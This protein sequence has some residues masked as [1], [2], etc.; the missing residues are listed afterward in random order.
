MALRA[1]HTPITH[2][3]PHIHSTT[4]KI[5]KVFNVYQS[6]VHEETSELKQSPEDYQVNCEAWRFGVETNTLRS[7]NVVPPEC[8]EYVKNYM[9]GSG[10]QYVRDSN[11]VANESIAYVN[12][13]QLS[14]DGKD[15]W[16]FDVDETL[17]STLPYFAAHQFGGEVIA[18][19]DFNVKWLDRAVAPALPASHKLYARLLE[20]GFKIFLLTGRR[21]CQRNVTER[22]LVR[23]GYHSWEALFLREPEDR[24]KSAVVYKSE[25]RLKIE[26]NG[27]RIRGNSGD[28]WSDLTGYSVGD[29]TFKLPN[30]MYYVA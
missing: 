15:A 4:R 9:I 10:S 1:A 14:G 25:R 12:S 21:H 24:A 30:P 16:V 11:M 3:H 17:I 8:V 23:A 13:L 7:W 28:Q 26:Q 6:T 22:N 5:P 19:D 29:R 18:E 20:L 2:Q 27:F